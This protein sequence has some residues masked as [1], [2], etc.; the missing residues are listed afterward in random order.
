MEN[1][2]NPGNGIQKTVTKTAISVDDIYKGDFQKEGTKTAQLRQVVKTTAL[3]PTK[4]VTSNHQDN[5]F[6]LVDFGFKATPYSNEEN[7]VCWIDVPEGISDKVDVLAAIPKDATL[8]RMLSNRPILT[9]HQ[10]Y[11]I[12]A[13]QKT[14]DD[15]ANSQSVRF[16]KGHEK[17]GQ[18]VADANGKPQY[19]AI[20]YSNTPKEDVDMRTELAE[21]FYASVQMRAELSGAHVIEG[22]TL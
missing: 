1:Q 3:Y 18:L 12:E 20:F 17:A 21:D 7:R 13:N 14:M 8:F 22:Q 9:N 11:S 10:L 16:S 4:Q 5:P 15:Y 6:S 2:G 19:R